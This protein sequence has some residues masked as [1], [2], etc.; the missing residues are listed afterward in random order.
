M[1]AAARQEWLSS[2]VNAACSNRAG[3]HSPRLATSMIRAAVDVN[4]S[5]CDV[6][7][8]TLTVASKA[9]P[10][11]FVIASSNGLSSDLMN[12]RIQAELHSSTMAT[13]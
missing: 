10:M 13:L 8:R 4:S 1:V 9:S 2:V 7:R 3:S 5:G 12:G 6:L 11:F